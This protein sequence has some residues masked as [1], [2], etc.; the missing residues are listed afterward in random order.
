MAKALVFQLDEFS[1]PL[2]MKKVDRSKLYGYKEVEVLD[3][4]EQR[5]ELATLAEDGRTVIGIGGTA[6]AYLSVDGDWCERTEI[7]PINLEGEEISP[8]PSSFSAPVDLKD[9]VPME[10]YLEH[11]IRLVY[12][13]HFDRELITSPEHI[14]AAQITKRYF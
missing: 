11:N 6:M 10:F 14:L 9:T 8:V 7:I 13:M 4:N 1:I 5:C 2:T 12:Q 3:E